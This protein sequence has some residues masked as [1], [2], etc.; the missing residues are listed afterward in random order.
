MNVKRMAAALVA[1]LAVAGCGDD[2]DKYVGDRY[3]LTVFAYN[4]ITGEPIPSADL[5]SGLSLYQGASKMRP[6]VLD[7]ALP[8]AVVFSGIP[9]DYNIGSSS[10]AGFNKVYPIVANITGYGLFQGE[11]SFKTG[12]SYG[13]A[14]DDLFAQVGTIYLYPLGYRAP[15]YRFTVLYNGKPV[16][17]AVVQLDPDF[18]NTEDEDW[19][20]DR[21]GGNDIITP[22]SGHARALQATTDAN[23]QVTFAGAQ[24]ALGIYYYSSLL[25]VEFEGAQLGARSAWVDVGF[26]NT[27]RIISATDLAPGNAYGLYVAYITN[28][29]QQVDASG[30]L[31]IVFSRP[32]SLA[33]TSFTHSAANVGTGATNTNPNVSLSSDGQTLTLTPSWSTTATL[34]PGATVTYAA[35]TVTVNG[36][37][38]AAAIPVFGLVTADNSG[39]SGTVVLARQ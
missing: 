7:S 38:G 15:D 4:A 27:D 24:L 39:I 34:N 31:T 1:C 5:A 13:D 12:T 18:T 30:T 2:G 8:G 19:F 37:P 36:Y 3:S 29:S 23:G 35:G 33:G 22:V 11:V 21:D 32:V 9:A 26:D 6:S 20:T 25:P 28:K 16:P 10:D 17:N 14:A